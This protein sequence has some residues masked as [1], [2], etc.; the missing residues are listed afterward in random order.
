M[1]WYWWVLIAVAIAA[2]VV[3]KVKVG[4]SFLRAMKK[5]QDERLKRA[6]ED[7]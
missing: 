2:F 5:K 6:E 7:E 1:Q 3:L 4:G